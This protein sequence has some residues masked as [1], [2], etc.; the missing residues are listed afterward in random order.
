MDA[1]RDFYWVVPGFNFAIGIDSVKSILTETP[2]QFEKVLFHWDQLDIYPLSSE[3]ANFTGT[4]G[5]KMVD[6][7]GRESTVAIIESGTVIKRSDGWKLLSGQS[8]ALPD[9]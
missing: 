9:Q 5:G 1:S 7:S 2:T 6:T 8:A 4:V 3:I